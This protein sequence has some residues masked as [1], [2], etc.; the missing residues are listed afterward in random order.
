M[1]ALAKG[2]VNFAVDNLNLWSSI[3]N[4][5][6]PKESDVPDGNQLELAVLIEETINPL[7]KM[8]P[9]LNAEKLRKRAQTLFASVQG[10]VQMSI[11]GRFVGTP[12]ELLEGEVEALVEA[13]TRGSH[14]AKTTQGDASQ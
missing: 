5:R 14:L 8:Q 4:H 2:Y 11:Y 9:D 13:M 12:S 1:Q 7:S 6:L 3:F 10:V